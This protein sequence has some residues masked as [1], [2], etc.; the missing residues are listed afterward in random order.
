MLFYVPICFNNNSFI[1]IYLILFFLFYP[2]LYYCNCLYSVLN[3]YSICCCIVWYSQLHFYW[4]IIFY[5]IKWWKCKWKRPNSSSY[6]K[7]ILLEF[8]AVRMYVCKCMY[9]CMH[10]FMYIYICIYVCI[11]IYVCMYVYV[12]VCMYVCIDI[13]FYVC[14][15]LCIYLCTYVCMHVLTHG[16]YVYKYFRDYDSNI[17][18]LCF[19]LF[20][21]LPSQ[22]K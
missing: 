8:V 22:H 15:Y 17:I 21:V 3:Y 4:F 5:L 7:N 18:D 11:Y 9:L 6:L 14:I 13:C 1:T 2:I 12:Y 10:A 16:M 20:H 19:S